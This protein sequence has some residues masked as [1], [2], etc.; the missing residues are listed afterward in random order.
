[1]SSFFHALFD[2]SFSEYITTKII[3]V[4]YVIAL[5]VAAITWLG[6]LVFSLFVL[7]RNGGG[8]FAVLGG[9]IFCPIGF[10][11]QVIV[12]RIGYEIL[13]VV[14]GIAENVHDMTWALTGGRKAPS[15]NPPAPQYPQPGQYQY[16]Q[17]PPQPQYPPQQP[18]QPPQPQYPQP[19]QYQYPPQQ[20]GGPQYPP[21]P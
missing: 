15:H 16:P 18:P 7:S 6:M 17:Q 9:I 12:V 8:A 19:G 1:M 3:K 10:I 21:K 13:I 14:F 11:I 20:P 4:L 2:L 5:I